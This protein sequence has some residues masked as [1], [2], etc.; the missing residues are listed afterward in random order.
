[1]SLN[2]RACS[3]LDA[4]NGRHLSAAVTVSWRV[5]WSALVEVELIGSNASDGKF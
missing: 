2:F 4:S 3:Y 1:M 5:H